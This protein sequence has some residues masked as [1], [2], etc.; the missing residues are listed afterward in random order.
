MLTLRQ[1]VEEILDY[2][3]TQGRIFVADEPFEQGVAAVVGLPVESDH[4]VFEL[5]ARMPAVLSL[6][7]PVPDPCQCS[8]A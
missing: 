1:P 5:S 8:G 7:R 3:I 2:G 4:A 6:S